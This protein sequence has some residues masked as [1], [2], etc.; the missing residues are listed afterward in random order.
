VTAQ[1]FYIR[2]G[3][4]AFGPEFMDAGIEHIAMDKR[5]SA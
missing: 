3:F 4:V 2:N 1:G 5:L